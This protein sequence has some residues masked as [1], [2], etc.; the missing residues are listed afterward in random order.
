MP[1]YVADYLADTQR[2]TT[3][4]H[5]AYLLLIMDYWMSGPLPDDDEQLA[6]VTKMGLREWKRLRPK[7]EQFFR[8][9]NG[10]WYHKR[11]DQEKQDAQQIIDKRRRAGT[12]GAAARWQTH[13]DANGNRNADAM[14]EAV[15]TQRQND[16]P[17]PSPLPKKKNKHRAPILSDLPDWVPQDAWTAWCEM[18]ISIKHPLSTQRAIELAIAKLLS[19]KEQGQDPKLVLE[20]SI[21]YGWQ[22]LFPLKEEFKAKVQAVGATCEFRGQPYVPGREPCGLP[23]AQ[24]CDA[25][26][27]RPLCAHHRLQV[28]EPETTRGG[29]PTEV[30]SVLAGMG[31]LR[32]RAAA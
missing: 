6:V 3:E 21:F 14:A 26:G 4:G 19:L 29:M 23:H 15:P 11:I 18:R 25:Y 12:A 2:L 20:Q 30:R 16:G 13:T 1:L 24:P 27:N 8:I 9:E 10:C 32:K 5:G 7:I 22:G 17:S 31:H 28:E